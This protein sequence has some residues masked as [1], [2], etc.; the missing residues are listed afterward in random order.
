[1]NRHS[2]FLVLAACALAPA[3]ASAQAPEG[4]VYAPGPFD[5]LVVDGAGQV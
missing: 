5:S 4:K 2:P 3:L 1:M